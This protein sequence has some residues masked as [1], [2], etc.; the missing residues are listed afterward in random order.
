MKIFQIITKFREGC[1]KPAAESTGDSQV[2]EHCVGYNLE[3]RSAI[4]DMS[5]FVRVQR[6]VTNV[7]DIIFDLS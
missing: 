1:K 3:A 7:N 4:A 5:R 2:V 6:L